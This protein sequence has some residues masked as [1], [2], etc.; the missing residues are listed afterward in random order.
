M[1]VGYVL[2][3]VYFTGEFE[4][5]TAHG[6]EWEVLVT[7]VVVNC[8]YTADELVTS[9]SWNGWRDM[10]MVELDSKRVDSTRG[11]IVTDLVHSL[12]N[13]QVILYPN[14]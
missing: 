12:G 2:E 8:G 5:I 13:D 9:F 14:E 11:G 4:E 7:D 1:G 3:G 6:G 10:V